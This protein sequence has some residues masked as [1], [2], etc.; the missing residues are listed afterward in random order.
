MTFAG[1]LVLRNVR[2]LLAALGALL[3]LAGI[4]GGEER[5]E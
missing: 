4:A 5:W 3:L 2:V 1:R